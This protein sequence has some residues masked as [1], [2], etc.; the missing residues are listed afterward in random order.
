MMPIDTACAAKIL[1]EHYYD[2][3][4]QGYET[5]EMISELVVKGGYVKKN[6]LMLYITK[7]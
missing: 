7:K 6:P 5:P 3:G 1:I 4:K 2:L